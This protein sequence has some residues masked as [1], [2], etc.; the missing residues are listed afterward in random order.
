MPRAPRTTSALVAANDIGAVRGADRSFRTDSAPSVATGS[1]DAISVSTA[2]VSGRVDP[3][4]RGTVVWFEYG[5]TAALGSP[6]AGDRRRLRPARLDA[7]G[8]RSAGLQPGTAYHYRIAARSDAGTTYGQTRSFRTSAGPLAVTGPARLSGTSVVLSGTV[9][10]V[11]RGTTFWFELGPS[12]SYGTRTLA[13]SAGA[14][15]GAVPVSETVTGL[16]PGTEY[17]ARLVAQSSAGTT[18]GADVV[19]R[20]AGAADRRPGERVGDLARASAHP[21]GGRERWAR[22]AGLGRVRPSA[23]R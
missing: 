23:G 10:P 16:A 17:H 3:R 19:F 4:G 8:A 21:C 14:G 9:D 20:T 13:R 6:N 15:R 7:H 5:P 22:D 1:V 11:G 12:T 18:P 2:R